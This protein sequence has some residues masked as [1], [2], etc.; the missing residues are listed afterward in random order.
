VIEDSI[1]EALRAET[2]G[3]TLGELTTD[4]VPGDR[5]RLVV[6]PL[7]GLEAVITHVLPGSERVRLL[8]EFLGGDTLAEANSNDV[9]P[10]D[11]FGSIMF[12]FAT[13]LVTP[14]RDNRLNG[15][16]VLLPELNS[17]NG[18]HPQGIRARSND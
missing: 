5:V 1:I 12:R 10:Y 14:P 6:G 3:G 4:L 16:K 8:L 17:P 9:I 13:R 2:E 15:A 7:A 11:H 18:V